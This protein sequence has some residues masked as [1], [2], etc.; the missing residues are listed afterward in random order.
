MAIKRASLNAFGS[1]GVKLRSIKYVVLCERGRKMSDKKIDQRI[2]IK[3]LAKLGLKPSEINKR[4][5]VV[6]GDE[7]L[8]QARVYEWVNRFKRG[9]E[10]TD[11]DPRPGQ[12]SITHTAANIERLR[13]L[14]ATD[15]RLTLQMLSEQLVINKESVRLMLHNDLGMRK[16]CAKMVPKIL[17]DEQKIKRLTVA[18]EMLERIEADG[19]DWMNSIVTGDETWVFQYD[20]ETK[21]QSMQWVGEDGSRP[22]KARMSRSQIKTM[23]IVFFD[24]NGIVHREFVPQGQTVNSIFYLSVLKRLKAR[25]HRVRPELVKNGW[26]LHHDNAP[27]HTA[28]IVTKY[29]ALKNITVLSQPPYS[30]DLAPCDYFLFPKTKSHL[31]GT[32]FEDLSAIQLNATR[33][34]NCVTLQEFRGCFDS[35]V[36]RWNRCVELL[37]EYCEGL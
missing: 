5:R 35:W 25:I 31:K 11:D 7:C 21:R 13:V 6:Y 23:L 36:R 27:V 28:S 33:V 17:T 32:C 3:F 34:L 18:S 20:P 22:K 30:P 14:I 37:G 1:A 2:N 16:L 29:L 24:V 15:Y 26:I 19:L 10:S 9:R 12:P 8:S 4:M